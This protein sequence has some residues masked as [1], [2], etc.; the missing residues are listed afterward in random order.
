[1]TENLPA[2]PIPV[3][4]YLRM[5]RDHQRYSIRNQARAIDVLP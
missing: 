2:S 1:M 3:A 5:S 4:Q